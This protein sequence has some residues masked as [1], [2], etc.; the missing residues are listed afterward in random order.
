MSPLVR[1]NCH[2]IT[3]RQVSDNELNYEAEMYPS[4]GPMTSQIGDIRS[5]QV[6]VVFQRP[7]APQVHHTL[8]SQKQSVVCNGCK[9]PCIDTLDIV[10]LQ[11]RW[12][13]VRIRFDHSSLGSSCRSIA[14][15]SE[16]Y[17]L[18]K[19]LIYRRLRVCPAASIE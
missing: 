16:A 2:I 10:T 5:G 9:S 7:P 6:H 12:W 17:C 13:V 3:F 11:A 1:V 18:A 14:L 19:K 4:L 15:D 8:V